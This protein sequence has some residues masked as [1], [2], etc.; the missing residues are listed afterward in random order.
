MAQVPQ[1]ILNWLHNVLSHV[2]T[3]MIHHCTLPLTKDRSIM[4][5]TG[6]TR[7]SLGLCRLT[8]TSPFEP[9]STVQPQILCSVWDLSLRMVA[10]ENGRSSLL[11]NVSGTVPVSFRGATY[12]FPVTLWVPLEFP[13]AAPITFV[14]PTKSMAVRAGQYVSA[15]GRVYHPYLAGWREDVSDRLGFLRCNNLSCA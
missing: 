13:R 12:M 15:E 8:P 14:T 6:P 2:S 11:L 5:S 3:S 9:M 1:K 10:Y 4:M 7:M